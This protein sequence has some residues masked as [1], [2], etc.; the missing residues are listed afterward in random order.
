MS[1]K[2]KFNPFKKTA[3]VATSVSQIDPQVGQTQKTE[4][5]D[6]IKLKSYSVLNPFIV[7]DLIPDL[8][9]I[10][11]QPPDEKNW[12]ID[13]LIN[14]AKSADPNNPESIMFQHPLQHQFINTYKIESDLIKNEPDLIRGLDIPCPKRSCDSKRAYTNTA[15]LRS[16]DEG[17]T[18][19]YLCIKCGHKWSIYN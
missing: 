2:V 13:A 12:G 3:T 15:Q 10:M 4:H 19:I 18:K 11:N 1:N 8:I 17:S 5:P 16:A 14:L 9:Y 7:P 6:I